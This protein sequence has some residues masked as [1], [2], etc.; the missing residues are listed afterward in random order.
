MSA[1]NDGRVGAGR[2]RGVDGRFT[3][4]G[5]R[6]TGRLDLR[7]LGVFPVVVGCN[8][9]AARVKQL[10]R[11]ILQRTGNAKSGERWPEGSEQQCLVY[12]SISPKN[13]PADQ[14]VITGAD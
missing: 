7:L 2:Q 10:E 14:D 12:H 5:R 11:R 6:K 1:A 13:E 3:V 8:D 9:N 4:I